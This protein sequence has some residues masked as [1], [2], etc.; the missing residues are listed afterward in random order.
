MKIKNTTKRLIVLNYLEGKTRKSLPLGGGAEVENEHLT[1]QDV[2]VYVKSG[3]IEVIEAAK[4]TAPAE[5]INTTPGVDTTPPPAEDAPVAL[6]D[7]ATAEAIK[8]ALSV[9]DMKKYLKE[10]NVKGYSK[11]SEDELVGMILASIEPK[12]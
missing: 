11:K 7:P 9:A 5:G 10:H 8:E 4:A 12:E 2:R 6:P 1:D 3:S